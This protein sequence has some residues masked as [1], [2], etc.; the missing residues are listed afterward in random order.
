MASMAFDFV[1]RRGR[2]AKHRIL[3]AWL[4]LLA[5]GLA[6]CQVEATSPVPTATP[7]IT[8]IPY[9]SPTPEQLTG[10]ND[11]ANSEVFPSLTPT[12]L[13]SP[14]P[15]P[16]TYKVK[17]GD[18]LLGIALRYGLTLEALKAANPKVDPNFLSVG[19]QLVIPLDQARNL[20]T[21]TPSPT[22]LPLTIDS[23]RCFPQGNAGVWC[24]SQVSNDQHYAVDNLRVA[25]SLA[26]TA[27][28]VLTRTQV[29]P[30]LDWI[31]AG[32]NL[33]ILAFFPSNDLPSGT[34]EM[35]ASAELSSAEPVPANGGRYLPLRAKVNQ[36]K[37]SSDGLQAVLQ[38]QIDYPQPTTPDVTN[39]TAQPGGTADPTP[40]PTLSPDMLKANVIWVLAVAYDAQGQVIGARRWEA[41]KGLKPTGSMSFAVTV[42]SLGPPIDRANVILE[43]RNQ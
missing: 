23:P 35:A 34:N 7:P 28:N 36:V 25:I 39:S 37:I 26:D 30:L 27:T 10:S 40:R 3:F 4:T 17:K 19:T 22:P 31:P 1:G 41:S 8:L 29:T 24:V 33:P 11:S 16:Y 38:G 20:P 42:Y 13:P 12:R 18:T 14:T 6:G 32:E 15:T 21:A 9:L 5:I 2:L 43:A